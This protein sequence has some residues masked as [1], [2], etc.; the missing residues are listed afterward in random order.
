MFALFS[1]FFGI[2]KKF[3]IFAWYTKYNTYTR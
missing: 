2:I 1:I 3:T